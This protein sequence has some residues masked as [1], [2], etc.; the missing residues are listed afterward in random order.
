VY[1]VLLPAAVVE[2]GDAAAA[3][4][5]RSLFPVLLREAE[6]LMHVGSPHKHFVFFVASLDAKSVL[7]FNS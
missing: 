1:R 2:S 7:R 5:P 6:R 3:C 4:V